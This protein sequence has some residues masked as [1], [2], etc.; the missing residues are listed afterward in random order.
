MF[1]QGQAQVDGIVNRQVVGLCQRQ[2]D[3]QG[4]FGG[5]GFDF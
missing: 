1:T 2:A 4:M 3:S 5:F